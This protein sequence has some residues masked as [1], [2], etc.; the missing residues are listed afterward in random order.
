MGMEAIVK[1]IETFC[2]TR[3]NIFHGKRTRKEVE[4]TWVD[5]SEESCQTVRQ[6]KSRFTSDL[7]K[8]AREPTVSPEE[9]AA[10]K[11]VQKKLRAS[12]NEEE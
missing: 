9:T 5:V 12:T 4:K 1:Y 7:R 6:P 11:L 8:R 3:I 10:R 2:R